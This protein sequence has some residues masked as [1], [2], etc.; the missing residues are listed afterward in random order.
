MK[1]LTI[2]KHLIKPISILTIV[3]MIV[4]VGLPLIDKS[5][6]NHNQPTAI[7]YRGVGLVVFILT[8]IVTLRCLGSGHNN[9]KKLIAYFITYNAFIILMKYIL[10][11]RSLEHTNTDSIVREI[12]SKTVLQNLLVAFLT[13]VVVFLIYYTVYAI[14]RHVAIRKSEVM[15]ITP[16]GFKTSIG[17][18]IV[19]IFLFSVIFGGLSGFAFL[20]IL[21]VETNMQY[22]GTIFTSIY[23][24][25]IVGSIIFASLVVYLTFREAGKITDEKKDQKIFTNVASLSILLLFAYHA[26]WIAFFATLETIWPYKMIESFFVR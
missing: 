18:F 8:I 21:L 25:G 1:I 11:P 15:K 13:A 14:V 12:N 20:A 16:E 19:G 7:S 3:G 4:A 2:P 23:A 6:A 24:Y 10:A 17:L 5:L 22:L 9:S 26:I